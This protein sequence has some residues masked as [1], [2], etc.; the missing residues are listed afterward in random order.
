MKINLI[1]QQKF[2]LTGLLFLMVFSLNNC[3]NSK[4]VNKS[5]NTQTEKQM[6]SDGFHKGTIVDYSAEKGCTFLIKRE[7]TGELLLPYKLEDQFMQDNLEV[8]FKY[9]YSRR[10][11]GDCLKGI[12]ITLG[13]IKIRN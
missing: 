4:A 13:E 1:T 11:Q 2:L 7:E 10:P 8:W 9:E 6:V 12:T 3:K 5:D